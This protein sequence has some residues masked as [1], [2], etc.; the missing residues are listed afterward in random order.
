MH[1]DKV[2]L[3]A[4]MLNSTVNDQTGG[5]DRKL[6]MVHSRYCIWILPSLFCIRVPHIDS[7]FF[8]C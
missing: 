2:S 4:V 6:N 5:H 8:L 1:Y 3:N 7:C